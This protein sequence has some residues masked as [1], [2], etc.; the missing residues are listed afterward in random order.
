M[1]IFAD[2]W[3]YAENH[4]ALTSGPSQFSRPANARTGPRTLPT[5]SHAPRQ[6]EKHALFQALTSDEKNDPLDG[7][8]PSQ[9]QLA[10]VST[11]AMFQNGEDVSTRHKDPTS[12]FVRR[13][14]SPMK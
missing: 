5:R 4:A 8:T 7:K 11:G 13:W 3:M 12:Y 1:L 2:D 9:V 14:L 6:P 10:P